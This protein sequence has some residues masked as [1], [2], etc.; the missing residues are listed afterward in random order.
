MHDKGLSAADL[1]GSESILHF[2]GGS[3]PLLLLPRHHLGPPDFAPSVL[4]LLVRRRDASRIV[5]RL[6]WLRACHRHRTRLSRS[7]CRC[8]ACT[9]HAKN[10][11]ALPMDQAMEWKW[12]QCHPHKA[13]GE[14]VAEKSGDTAGNNAHAPAPA[15]AV[16]LASA[17]SAASTAQPTAATPGRITSPSLPRGP[18]APAHGTVTA[19]Q[20]CRT[21]PRTVHTSVHA[22]CVMMRANVCLPHILQMTLVHAARVW[23]AFE[24]PQACCFWMNQQRM[25]FLFGTIGAGTQDVQSRRSAMACAD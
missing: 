14:E 2:S 8:V 13:W 1:Q 21:S 18:G 15:S 11:S 3:H 12:K 17:G 24:I 4:R 19:R 5:E 25:H 7:R 6:A 9:P 22:P 23:S 10:A 16:A 20:C